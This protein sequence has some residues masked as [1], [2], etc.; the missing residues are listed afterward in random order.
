MLHCLLLTKVVNLMTNMG[1]AV[2]SR[3]SVWVPAINDLITR[4]EWQPLPIPTFSCNSFDGSCTQAT[5][6]W[7]PACQLTY[8]TMSA[9]DTIGPAYPILLPGVMNIGRCWIHTCGVLFSCL[10]IPCQSWKFKPSIC[11]WSDVPNHVSMKTSSSA[12]SRAFS[13]K[14]NDNQS[15][16]SALCYMAQTCC[17]KQLLLSCRRWWAPSE[18]DVDDPNIQS[19]KSSSSVWLLAV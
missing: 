7:Q 18:W 10:L 11:F 19:C 2:W 1:V 17:C 12:C 4:N 14:V 5:L 16:R 6:A 15:S 9:G 8:K 3:S 13:L